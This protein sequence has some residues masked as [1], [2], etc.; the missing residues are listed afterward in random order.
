MDYEIKIIPHH[1]NYSIDLF[2]DIYNRSGRILKPRLRKRTG[3]LA[4]VLYGPKR[5][6]LIHRLVAEMFIPNP[7]NKPEV[8]HKDGDKYHNYFMNLEWVTHSENEL[9]SYKVLGKQPSYGKSSLCSRVKRIKDN[10]EE[11]FDSINDATRI[12]GYSRI[13]IKRFINQ[14]RIDPD[15]FS[16]YNN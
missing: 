9:H 2:G 7:E 3:Y 12:T 6:Y 10:K 8:N 15:G 13:L 4:V 1:P 5:S 14:S 16:W 11:N